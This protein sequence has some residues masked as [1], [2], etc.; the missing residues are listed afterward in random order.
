MNQPGGGPAELMASTDLH[1]LAEASLTML[2]CLLVVTR[3]PWMRRE[4]TSTTNAT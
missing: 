4:I 2:V 1:G 3:Q